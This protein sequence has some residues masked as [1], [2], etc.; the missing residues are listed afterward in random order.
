MELFWPMEA[1]RTPRVLGH[2]GDNQLKLVTNAAGWP[3]TMHGKWTTAQTGKK[4]ADGCQ[5]HQGRQ[6]TGIFQKPTKQQTSEAA[7]GRDK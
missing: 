1:Y 2:V 6:H 3:A 5:P 4:A 7:D